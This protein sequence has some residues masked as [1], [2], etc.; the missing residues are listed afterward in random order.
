MTLRPI[1]TKADWADASA[2]ISAAPRLAID[3]EADGFHRYPERVALIQVAL[4]DG[5]I[6]LV[7]PLAALDLDVLGMRLAE[8]SVPVV[9]HSG[10]YDVRAL[11]RDLGFRIHGLY[12]T[13]IAAQLSGLDRLGLGTVLEQIL[14]VVLPKPK[15]LQ[16]FDWSS[17]PLPADA[18]AYAAGDVVHLLRLADALAERIAALGR[19]AWVAEECARLEGVRHAPPSPPEEA[20]LRVTGARDLDGRGRAL[21]RELSVF[22]EAEALRLGRPPHFVLSNAAMLALAADPEARP[23][24][25]EGIGRHVRGPAAGRLREALARGLA[26]EPVPWPP[27]RGVSPWTGPARARLG[28]LKRWRTRE[29]AALGLDPGIVWP[30]SH[31]ERMALFPEADPASLDV[32]DPPAIR[33]WQMAALGPSLQ[34][35]HAGLDV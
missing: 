5:S 34:A 8:P 6:Y 35:F 15:R 18:L 31:L 19:T 4:P 7:D 1:D 25:V 13:S 17:R 24:H 26:A 32:D 11:D 16:R 2:A 28:R 20:F 12:D 27:P 9:L 30:A 33:R 14:G 10:S 3:V 22:R 21:L 29:A 23:E